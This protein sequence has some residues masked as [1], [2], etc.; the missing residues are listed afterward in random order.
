MNCQSVFSGTFFLNHQPLKE[1]NNNVQPIPFI[2]IA[3]P[4]T[5]E[6]TCCLPFQTHMNPGYSFLLFELKLNRLN[7]Q[8][9]K[10]KNRAERRREMAYPGVG[11]PVE[12]EV[13]ANATGWDWWKMWSW[14]WHQL[15]ANR[16]ATKKPHSEKPHRFTFDDHGKFD[17]YF[18]GTS[19]T[20]RNYRHILQSHCLLNQ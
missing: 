10:N 2:S 16:K 1:E 4:I 13:I 12:Y 9:Q 18:D 6:Q 7:V 15:R 5:R 3:K 11:A 17:S 20:P 19:T 8:T 14:D